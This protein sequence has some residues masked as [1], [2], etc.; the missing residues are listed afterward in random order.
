MCSSYASEN[1]VVSVLSIRTTTPNDNKVK[2]H[3]FHYPNS[4]DIDE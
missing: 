4:L 2:V 1:L 3:Q